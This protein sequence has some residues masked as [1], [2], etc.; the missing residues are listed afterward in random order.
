ML[1][2]ISINTAPQVDNHMSMPEKYHRNELDDVKKAME[3]FYEFKEKLQ[4]LHPVALEY[5]ERLVQTRW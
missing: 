3:Y 1:G 4:K 2:R 5:I